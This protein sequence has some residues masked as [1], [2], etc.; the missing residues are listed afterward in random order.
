MEADFAI[1]AT[2]AADHRR[3]AAVL[4]ERTRMAREIHD[5]L[6]QGFAG[7]T[8]QLEAA[9]AA[10]ENVPD[11]ASAAGLAVYKVQMEKIRARIAKARDLARESLMEARRSMEALRSSSLE[12]NSLSEALADLLTQMVWG[13]MKSRYVLTG[14]P[15]PLPEEI[16][17]CLLRTGQEAIAN[18]VKHAQAQEVSMELSF[19][20]ERVRLRV[21]D[22]GRG[23]DT[24]LPSAGRLGII[25]M[26][27]RAEQVG[28]TLSIVSYL[29][30]GTNIELIVPVL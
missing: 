12:A 4:E 27:E 9:E 1:A 22:N 14:V 6:A 16:E 15:R 29:E 26:K 10:L 11:P 7:I 23:F 21:H 5:M 17:H 13:T 30:K 28:G 3:Q 24:A 8:V 19:E 20:P 2:A 18:A 25:G